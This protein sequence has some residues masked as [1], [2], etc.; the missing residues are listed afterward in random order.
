MYHSIPV[1]LGFGRV[2]CVGYVHVY[3][4]FFLS[5]VFFYSLISIIITVITVIIIPIIMKAAPLSEGL[6][7]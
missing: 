4:Y 2:R 7:S 1:A 5:P 6:N 3:I